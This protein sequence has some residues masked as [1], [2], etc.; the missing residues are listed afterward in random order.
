MITNNEEQVGAG[1]ADQI[2]CETV[3]KTVACGYQNKHQTFRIARRGLISG[4]RFW[5]GTVFNLMEVWFMIDRKGKQ[6]EQE[7]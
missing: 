5:H 7:L 1:E 3:N 6:M 4:H 2:L